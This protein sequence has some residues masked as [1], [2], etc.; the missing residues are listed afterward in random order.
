M[1]KLVLACLFLMFSE[2]VLATPKVLFLGAAPVQEG[3]LEMLQPLA[4]EGV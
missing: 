2:F 1:K 3:K 4:L